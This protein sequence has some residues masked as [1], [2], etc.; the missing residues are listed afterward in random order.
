MTDDWLKT[1]F[2]SPQQLQ[3]L[4]QAAGDQRERTLQHKLWLFDQLKLH[5]AA[6]AGLP[7]LSE[8]LAAKAPEAMKE[9][10]KSDERFLLRVQKI[11]N[12][13]RQT[14]LTEALLSQ[15]DTFICAKGGSEALLVVL[16]TAYNNIMI[17][18]PV[19]V[20][21][22]MAFGSAKADLL[23]VK[24]NIS[25]VWPTRLGLKAGLEAL[26]NKLTPIVH[27]YRGKRIVF[28]GASS[29]GFPAG[30]LAAR[31]GVSGAILFGA[32]TDLT[33]GSPLPRRRVLFRRR[34]DTE[35]EKA[36]PEPGNWDLRTVA[37]ISEL[38]F[39]DLYC[40]EWDRI[41]RMHA[42]HLEGMPNVTVQTVPACFHLCIP[43]LISAGG[44][45][46]SVAHRLDPNC[47]GKALPWTV[48]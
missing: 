48:E 5:G 8:L 35:R 18:F 46:P 41:D 25:E 2:H 44:F 34:K 27:G 3:R 40:G 42:A 16:P 43:G 36:N 37:G 9:R 39:L 33:D 1:E 26:E 12:F 7:I 4:L 19:L 15:S 38:E 13:A 17:S 30:Y 21:F 47:A 14:N 24:K 29:G 22:F 11:L 45:W 28:M 6:H 32:S 31:L 20:A 10:L 23:I